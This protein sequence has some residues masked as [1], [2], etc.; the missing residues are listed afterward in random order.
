MSEFGRE[1]AR[2]MAA[3]GLGVRE[4]ARLVPCNPG[5]ISNLRNGRDRPSPELAARLD[6]ALAAGGEIIEA[7]ARPVPGT[8]PGNVGELVAP[9][10]VSYF[11]AQLAGHYSADRFLGPMRLIPVALSQYELLC[12]VAA[13]AAS[14]LRGELWGVAAGYAALIGWLYQDAGDLVTSARWHAA[15]IERAHRSQDLQ[16]VSFALY[17][18]AMLHA[19]MKDGPGVLDLTG[20]RCWTPAAWSRRSACFSSS[21]PHTAP[22][23]RAATTRRTLATGSSARPP[24]CWMRSATATRGAAPARHRITSTSSARPSSPGLAGPVKR[25]N[26]G[27]RSSPAFPV[28][29]AGTSACSAPGTRRPSPRLE[30]RSMPRRSPRK[31]CR[32]RR[33]PVRPGC[34]QNSPESTGA[35]PR[36]EASRLAGLSTKRSRVSPRRETASWRQKMAP[37]DEVIAAP[38]LRDRLAVLDS[39]HGGTAGISKDYQVGYDDAIR[40]VG[41]VGKVAIELEHRPDID[42]RWDRLHVFLTTHTAGNVVT[43]LDFLLASRIDAIAAAHG[44][45]PVTG[46]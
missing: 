46:P 29:L 5:H 44:A 8:E 27:S 7:A 15:M 30:N 22:P 40:I 14:G 20:Q 23:S 39:W 32:S 12:D 28:R 6:E 13:A 4:L 42:I 33:A 36:G 2:L 25:P 43:E 3:R 21:R 31:S 11:A 24:V 16:L 18:K 9:E 37:R 38:Q 10:L 17:C 34:A 26:F 41:D 19:D 45:T 1:L 35:W